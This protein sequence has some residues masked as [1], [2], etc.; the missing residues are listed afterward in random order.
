MTK[1]VKK[2]KKTDEKPA[3]EQVTV[4][5][6]KHMAAL[7]EVQI[8]PRTEDVP[9]PQNIYEFFKEKF[10][11]E[12]LK[13]FTVK[14]LNDSELAKRD[15]RVVSSQNIPEFIRRA[16]SGVLSE[17]VEAAIEQLGFSEKGVPPDLVAKYYAVE[18]GMVAPKA[19]HQ[20]VMKLFKM[21]PV[22]MA[23][24]VFKT[25]DRLSGMG[26]NLGE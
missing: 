26:Y 10:P 12:N 25:I 7:E 16:A 5:G 13:A 11:D 8:K 19:N 6:P 15:Q 23:T 21:N 17:R 9:L 2:T 22:W 4:I 1:K 24:K 20:M 3:P 14:G 18:F